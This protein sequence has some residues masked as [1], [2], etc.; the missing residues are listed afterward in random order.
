MHSKLFTKSVYKQL[1]VNIVA[2]TSVDKW[3]LELTPYGVEICVNDIFTL[4]FKTTKDSSIQWMQYRL[5]HRIKM[6]VKY[7]LRKLM[8]YRLTVV[9]FAIRKL[10]QFNTFLLDVKKFLAY[11]VVYE[12]V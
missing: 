1:N 6:P 7:Y 2:P 5:L 10:K 11:E 8:F 9:L 12:V 3:N 4:C